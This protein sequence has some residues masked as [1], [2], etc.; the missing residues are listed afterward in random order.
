[1]E[2]RLESESL[3]LFAEFG[4]TVRAWQKLKFTGATW[5]RLVIE[6][7]WD[8]YAT[9]RFPDRGS[10]AF[11]K[12]KTWR[13][14][15]FSS[16]DT[17]TDLPFSPKKGSLSAVCFSPSWLLLDTPAVWAWA[18]THNLGQQSCLSVV[19]L[20][21]VKQTQVCLPRPYLCVELG[22]RAWIQALGKWKVSILLCCPPHPQ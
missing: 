9:V 21:Y 4:S 15:R 11:I 12:K 18:M 8:R 2:T 13:W 19:F 6:N 7:N 1:M 10:R 16:V 17:D 22:A 5:G 3:L 20:L 14:G